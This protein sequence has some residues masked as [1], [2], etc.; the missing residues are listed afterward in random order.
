MSKTKFI[1]SISELT[2]GTAQRIKDGKITV[3]SN[4]PKVQKAITKKVDELTAKKIKMERA[5][6]DTGGF[7]ISDADAKK[8]KARLKNKTIKRRMAAAPKRP[9]KEG[10]Y[11]GTSGVKL[12]KYKVK[13]KVKPVPTKVPKNKAKPKKLKTGGMTSKGMKNGGMMKSKGMRKGGKK[14][15]VGIAKRGFGKALK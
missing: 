8:A 2:K 13:G 10:E 15:G 1:K 11:I 4:D 3:K 12:S 6:Q 5:K 9:N 14:R 7:R